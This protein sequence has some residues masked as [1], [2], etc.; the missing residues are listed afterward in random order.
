MIALKVRESVCVCV[1]VCVRAFMCECAY[2]SVF[3]DVVWTCECGLCE[4]VCVWMVNKREWMFEWMYEREYVYVCAYV[5]VLIWVC[6]SER[7]RERE[8]ERDVIGMNIRAKV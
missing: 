8:R 3:V 4:Y 7:E 5:C 1:C 6:L 2:V